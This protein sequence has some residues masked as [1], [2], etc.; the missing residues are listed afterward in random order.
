MDPDNRLGEIWVQQ[1][2]RTLEMPHQQSDDETNH[3]KTFAAIQQYRN[4]IRDRNPRLDPFIT[5]M[6]QRLKCTE[7]R[8]WTDSSAAIPAPNVTIADIESTG[9]SDLQFAHEWTDGASLEWPVA[10]SPF[11]GMDPSCVIEQSVEN[12][13]AIAKVTAE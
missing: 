13:N 2:V 7:A 5:D 3:R 11:V 1:I 10:L 6:L 8:V 9:T 12:S 4:N